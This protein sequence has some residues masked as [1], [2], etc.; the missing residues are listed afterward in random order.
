MH[1][2]SEVPLMAPT[3]GDFSFFLGNH[4]DILWEYIYIYVYMYYV[5]DYVYMYICIMK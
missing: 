4:G 1:A 3:P 2:F 5:Y